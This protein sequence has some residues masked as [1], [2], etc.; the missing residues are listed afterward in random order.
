MQ[1]KDGGGQLVPLRKTWARKLG[2]RDEV[3]CVC[4]RERVRDRERR[5]ERNGGE[6]G[7]PERAFIW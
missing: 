2:L 6:R 4:E 1:E 3:W 5:V 7:K